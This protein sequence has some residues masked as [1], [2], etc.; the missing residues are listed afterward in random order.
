MTELSRLPVADRAEE[1]AFFPSEYSLSQYTSKVTDFDGF[2]FDKPYTGGKYRILMIGTDERY[3]LTQNGTMFSTGN[4][5][6]ETL[7]PMLHVHEAGFPIDVVTLSGNPVKFE[8]WAMP[9]ED[10]A[11]ASIYQEYLAQIKTP[12]KLGDIIDQVTAKDSPY[13]G[14]M[15]PGGHGAFSCLPHSKEVKRI[16]NWALNNDK[17][18]IT[19]CH[20]PA[21]L[22]SASIDEKLEDFPL[23]GYELCVFP[24]SLDE[25]ANI[26]IGYIPGRLQWLVAERLEELG[27][28]VINKAPLTGVVHKDRKLLTGDSPLAAN[29]LGI[30]AADELLKEVARLDK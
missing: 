2:K 10:K 11:I 29:N 7:L 5:P 23:K 16:L 28:K 17:F 21:A 25:G 9:T 13:I 26:D 14:V 18:I 4:H 27:M 1:N 24:D 3:L 6:V 22:V 30:L 15:I 19:L 8:M 12:T 20:G